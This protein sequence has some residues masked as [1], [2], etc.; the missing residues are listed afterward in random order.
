MYS[1]TL[2]IVGALLTMQGPGDYNVVLVSMETSSG[3]LVMVTGVLLSRHQ[4]S[5]CKKVWDLSCFM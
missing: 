1:L 5:L 3:L 2:S 4:W